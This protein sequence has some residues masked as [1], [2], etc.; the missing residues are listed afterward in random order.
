MKFLSF[1]VNSINAYLKKDLLHEWISENPD[2]IGFEE[3]KMSET[4]HENFPLS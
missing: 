2:L 3:L 1:N 4:T